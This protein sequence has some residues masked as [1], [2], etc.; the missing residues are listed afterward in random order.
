MRRGDANIKF[1][2]TCDQGIS[3]S[4]SSLPDNRVTANKNANYEKLSF[5]WHFHFCSLYIIRT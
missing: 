3:A 5:H 2:M 4:G 1:A